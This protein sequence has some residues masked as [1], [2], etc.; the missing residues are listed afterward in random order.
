VSLNPIP[1][2]KKAVTEN[3][4]TIEISPDIIVQE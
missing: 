1:Q 3:Q 2:Q 4:T